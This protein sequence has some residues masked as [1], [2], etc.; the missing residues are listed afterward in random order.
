MVVFV[1]TIAAATGIFV[2]MLTQ[3]KQQ[4]KIAE[5]NI[6]NIIG[7]ELLKRDIEHAG[8]GLP[9]NIPVGLTYQ[10]ASS[11]PA[12]NYNEWRLC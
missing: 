12:S 7:L 5:S 9:W 8:F 11:S 3:F 4:S 2:P 10:E 1:L 6:E